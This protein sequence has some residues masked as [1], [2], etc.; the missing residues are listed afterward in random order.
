MFSLVERLFRD[1]IDD[2]DPN[3]LNRFQMHYYFNPT[4]IELFYK[5]MRIYNAIERIKNGNKT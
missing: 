1:F 5:N 2:G 3:N 4:D